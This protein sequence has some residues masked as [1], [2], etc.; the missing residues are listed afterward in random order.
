LSVPPDTEFP[1]TRP[2]AQRLE[3]AARTV[4]IELADDDVANL[5]GLVERVEAGLGDPSEA[6]DESGEPGHPGP[7][8]GS[9]SRQPDDAVDGFVWRIAGDGMP[10]TG[11]GPLDGWRLAVKDL[12]AVAGHARRCG[13]AAMFDAKV[14]KTDAPVVAALRRA[15][16]RLVG[17]THL[18][19][20]AFGTTG[21]N[22]AFGTPANPV[23][24]DRVPGGS[25]SGAAVAVAAGQADVSIGSDTGGSVRIPASLCGVVGFKPAFGSVSTEGV[26]PLSTSLDHVGYL[27]AVTDELVAPAIA[28][29]LIGAADHLQRSG[30]ASGD[31]A[32]RLRL[33]VAAGA[34]ERCD[35]AVAS[36]FRAALDGLSGAGAELVELEWPGGEDVFAA[37]TAIMYAEAAHGHRRLLASRHQLYGP[38]VRNRLLQGMAMRAL[39]YLQARDEQARLRH[40][41]LTTLSGLDGV[42]CPT[43]PVVAP[44]RAEA[45]DPAVGARLVTFTRLADV[46]GLPAVSIPLPGSLLEPTGGLPVGLQLEAAT[47]AAALRTAVMLGALL[48]V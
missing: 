28:L 42:L 20:F 3:L 2:V 4:G 14:E 36:A 32:R 6:A 44:P 5:A 31:R 23:A 38:D 25:S 33:G 43:V 9:P 37:T 8:P 35:E 41:C 46:A 30:A 16:A 40:R 47:D 15:G 27:V 7:T 17:G 12:V 21:L 22:A 24:P 11:S 18:H 48:G 19:E 29:G 39:T 10:A 13:S 34:T 26:W 1:D 45:A